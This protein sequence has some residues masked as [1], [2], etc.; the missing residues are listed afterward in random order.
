VPNA[1]LTV[2]GSDRYGERTLELCNATDH[3]P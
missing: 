1:G 2:V 3:L